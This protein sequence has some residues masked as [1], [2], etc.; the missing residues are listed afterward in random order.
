MKKAIVTLSIVLA[1]G[2]PTDATAIILG[3]DPI[4][5]MLR[6]TLNTVGDIAVSVALAKNEN[7]FDAE[8]YF[9]P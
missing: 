7:L 4:C 1:L 6:T 5:S 3:I 9:K 2:L 8:I